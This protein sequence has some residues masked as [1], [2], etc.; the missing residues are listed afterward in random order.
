[1]KRLTQLISETL[2]CHQE[3]VLLEDSD[4]AWTGLD[5][6]EKI[7]RIEDLLRV[8]TVEG[9]LVGICYPN[10][11][12][13]GLAILAVIKA[14]RV[15]VIL[16]YDDLVHRTQSWLERVHLDLLLTTSELANLTHHALNTVA[17]SPDGEI[18]H[19]IERKTHVLKRNLAPVGT[20]LVLYTSGSTGNPKGICVPEEGIILTCDY[21]REYFQLNSSTVTAIVLPVCHSMALNTQFLPTFFSGGRSAFVNS[22]L[23][24]NKLFRYINSIE[25]NFVS[26][27]GEVLRIC[28]EEK[29]SKNLPPNLGVKHVQLAGGIITEKHLQLAAELFPNATIHKGYGLTEGIRV[30]MIDH[31][32]PRFL[33]NVVGKPLPFIKTQIR[34]PDGELAALD[35]VGEVFVQG[36]N[37]MLGILGNLLSPVGEDGYLGTGDLGSL[38]L[39]GQLSIYG[40]KDSVFKINGLKVSGLEIERI[41]SEVSTYVRDSKCILVEDNRKVR[42][43]IIL[44][45]EIPKDRHTEFFSGYFEI[46]HKAL[47]KEFRSLAYFPRDIIILPRFPRTSNGKLAIKKLHECWEEQ[48]REKMSLETHGNMFFYKGDE[49]Q[50]QEVL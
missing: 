24:M 4:H 33:E 36:P 26:L 28:W 6:K 41:A 5:L 22:R 45:L 34:L 39:K 48:N 3:K 27:I 30:T 9:S 10:L 18:E 40:R 32:D 14:K 43:K 15:P 21:L 13:Q 44:F 23:Q 38:N 11:A 29:K 25:G 47:W 17:L 8:S 42:N 37:V 19:S 35:E 49:E 2:E 7:Q 12:Y 46:F 50:L 31:H 1:M 20:G 16:S